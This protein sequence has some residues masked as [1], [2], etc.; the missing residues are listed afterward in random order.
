MMK[1]KRAMKYFVE[2]LPR[3]GI[4]SVVLEVDKD[5]I[6][7]KDFSDLSLTIQSSSLETVIPLPYQINKAVSPNVKYQNDECII[8]FK[9]IDNSFLSQMDRTSNFIMSFSHRCKWSRAELRSVF[10]FKCKFCD[11]VLLS[12]DDCEK[13]SDMPSEFWAELMD[14]WNCHKPFEDS[15]KYKAYKAK[16]N[17]LIPRIGELLIGDS[18]LLLNSKW[19]NDRFVIDHGSPRCFKCNELLGEVTKDGLTKIYKWHLSLSNKDNQVENYS[20][21]YSIVSSLINIINS[22]GVRVI[23]ISSDMNSRVLIWV[24]GVGIDVTLS[25]NTTIKGGLKI[26]YSIERDKASLVGNGCQQIETL[27]IPD[28]CYTKFLESLQKTNQRLPNNHRKTNGWCISYI[29]TS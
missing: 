27:T 6:V 22:H 8:R 10:H 4:V 18:F 1:T 13:L 2:H 14:Y 25:N 20:I 5:S 7:V 12:N 17:T 29:S 23:D 19:L 26:L 9:T 15:M 24:F 21:E 3:I 28:L 11:V 16:Y